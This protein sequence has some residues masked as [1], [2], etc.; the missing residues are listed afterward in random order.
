[1]RRTSYNVLHPLRRKSAEEGFAL[2]QR[3]RTEEDRRFLALADV[4]TYNRLLKE[5]TEDLARVLA[6]ERIDDATR[7]SRCDGILAMIDNAYEKLGCALVRVKAAAYQ[8][9]ETAA[10]AALARG[11]D[12][13]PHRAQSGLMPRPR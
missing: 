10:L 9:D 11:E 4:A 6:D 2:L 1:M 5:R 7:A 8:Q 3:P 12:P 13:F